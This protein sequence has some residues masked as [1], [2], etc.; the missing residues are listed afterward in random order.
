MIAAY[1]TAAESQVYLADKA[2][3]LDLTETEQDLNLSWGRVYIDTEFLCAYDETD[4]TDNIKYANALL[5]YM[6]FD[7]QLFTD[8]PKVDS[9]SVTAG[10][11]TTTK[12]YSFGWAE[13]PAMHQQA[14]ML[15]SMDCTD[16]YSAG[17][18]Q[19]VQS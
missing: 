1:C 13:E 3:W 7:G 8:A 2:D 10:P 6:A 17:E 12:S 16:A 11:V 14:T 4:A 19:I 9:T 5:G 15:L 18:S